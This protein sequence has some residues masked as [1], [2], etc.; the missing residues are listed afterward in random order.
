MNATAPVVH[1]TVRTT[2]DLPRPTNVAPTATLAITPDRGSVARTVFTFDPTGSV[3]MNGD[4]IQ[5]FITPENGGLRSEIFGPFTHQLR[6]YLIDSA[7]RIRN[8]YS[9]GFLDPRLVVGDVR[10]LLLEEAKE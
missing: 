1:A 10:T 4:G 2:G 8:I 3:D 9:L 6:V 5:I 7:R